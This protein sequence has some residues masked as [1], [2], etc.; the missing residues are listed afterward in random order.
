MNITIQKAGMQ[1]TMRAMARKRR[2]RGLVRGQKGFALIEIL[3]AIAILGVVAVAFLSALTAAYGAVIV[4]DRHTRA[5]SLTRTA[6][7]YMRNLPYD[8][9][10]NFSGSGALPST[11]QDPGDSV[12]GYPYLADNNKDYMVQVTSSKL[13]DNSTWE[14][15][16]VILYRGTTVD[17]TTTYRSDPN[18]GL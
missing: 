12:Y 14:I 6:F 15:T 8:H 13:D 7:E 2:I 18:K 4:A 10:S 1:E 11:W 17:T 9:P 5:E 16:V 3:A